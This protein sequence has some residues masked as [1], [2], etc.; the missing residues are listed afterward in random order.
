MAI[1]SKE[2]K[3]MM[4]KSKKEFN[5]SFENFQKT[6]LEN[7][8]KFAVDS[9]NIEQEIKPQDS[10]HTPEINL[11]PLSEN[12]YYVLDG[13]KK[14]DNIHDFSEF[15][16]ESDNFEKINKTLDELKKIIGKFV[17]FQ[18]QRL[19]EGEV[20]S[21]KGSDLLEYPEVARYVRFD[22]LLKFY[23]NLYNKNNSKD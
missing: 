11:P 10:T 7:D 20:F 15:Y 22:Q 16:N 5:A 14:V 1:M 12:A 8:S 18:K 4:D 2:M 3:S 6:K 17:R 13:L 21:S 19:N 9:K 23:I